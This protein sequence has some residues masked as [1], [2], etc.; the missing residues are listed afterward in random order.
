M[1]QKK[2]DIFISYR[3][4]GG[5]QYARIL[6]L[7]LIQRGYS[8][9]LDYDELRDGNFNDKI[10][11]AVIEA[12]VFM[13]V[14]SENALVRCVNED[15]WVREE[16]SLA[17]K[18]NKHII[19]VNPDNKFNGVPDGLPENIKTALLQ[20]QYSEV[21]FGQALGVT[22]EMM[23]NDRLVPSLGKRDTQQHYDSSYDAAME[24]LR[25]ADQHNKFIKHLGLTAAIVI[26]L[27]VFAT[28]SYLL[29]NQRQKD[30]RAENKELLASKRAELEKQ[31]SSYNLYLDK[32]LSLQQMQTIEDILE[33]M[34]VVKPDALWMS[35]FECTV[36]QWYG[37][38]GGGYDQSMSGM[39]MT[40]VSY[41][42]ICFYI[43]KLNRLLNG[44]EFS[45][46]SAEEWEY[47]AHGG[48]YHETTLYVGGD[49]VDKVAWYKDNSGNR[50]HRSD[51]QQGKLPNILDL[52]DMSGNV[53]EF[54]N[55]AFVSDTSNT[56]Y[57]VC[58]GGFRSDASEVTA[59]SKV[60][61]DVNAKDDAVGFRLIAIKK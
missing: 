40:N 59:S 53:G 9:F 5:A 2:Y 29:L 35:Q 60:G 28:C 49:D 22:V 48:A 18:E 52:Y 11:A 16:I 15:D 8:V 57:T 50:A 55:T 14:M 33:K 47:A 54:C 20:N 38:M 34:V 61:I 32:N 23:I 58:G 46:P 27:L 13:I 12:P 41:G 36:D 6:Q 26:I 7:M 51:G 37:I 10:R 24:T 42:E 45:L 31:Y 1:A 25:K 43:I 30:S 39:P 3:R 56:L 21:N 19:P 44:V 4:D 17:I